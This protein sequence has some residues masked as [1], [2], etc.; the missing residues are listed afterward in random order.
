MSPAVSHAGGVRS[1]LLRRGAG[2]NHLLQRED[3]RSRREI[4]GEMT[5]EIQVYCP[6]VSFDTSAGLL[7][8]GI[9][10]IN[11]PRFDPEILVSIE[12]TL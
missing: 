5:V 7:C 8:S 12:L 4:S 3:Q 1:R 2:E 10:L 6:C 9:V 11:A